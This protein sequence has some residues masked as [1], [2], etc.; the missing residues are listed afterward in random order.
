[1]GGTNG[2]ARVNTGGGAYVDGGVSTGGDFVGRDQLNIQLVVEKLDHA[3]QSVGELLLTRT[4]GD[5]INASVVADLTALMEELRKTHS[6]IV[7]LISPLR[8]MDDNPATFAQDFKKYYDDFRD[9]YDSYDFINERTHCSKIRHIQARL[10]RHQA[11]LMGSA[12]WQTLQ[13]QL[14]VLADF[15]GD[16]IEQLYMPF[17]D[18]LNTAINE[19]NA[20]LAA[21]Q[22]DEAVAHKR[23][24]LAVVEPEFDRTKAMLRQMNDTI[25][26][27]TAQL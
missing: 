22:V 24:L 18:R 4:P 1:M 19:I 8:R 5:L 14:N 9:F 15:D 2:D 21:G 27:L 26:E 23:A 3:A 17:M 10:Q 12:T 11:P 6:T 7:R 13:V 20:R 16:V 25:N